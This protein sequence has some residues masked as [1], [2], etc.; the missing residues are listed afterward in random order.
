MAAWGKKRTEVAGFEYLSQEWHLCNISGPGWRRDIL[1]FME[2]HKKDY[3][4]AKS[5]MIKY[6]IAMSPPLPVNPMFCQSFGHGNAF[7]GKL[8]VIE[9]L[10]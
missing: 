10:V 8:S 4:L 5:I 3:Y 1:S 9:T 2:G 6:D 7:W